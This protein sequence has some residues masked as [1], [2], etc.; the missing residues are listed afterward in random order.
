MLVNR[1]RRWL[2]TCA[3]LGACRGTEAS[4]RRLEAAY[5][6]PARAYHNIRHVEACLKDLDAVSHLV[7]NPTVLEAAIWFHDA[8]YDSRASDNEERSADLAA[9]TL[10]ATGVPKRPIGEIQRLIRHTKH[11]GTPRTLDG[12]IMVDI[13]LAILGASP[14]VFWRY[15]S[16]I[17]KEYAW[18]EASVYR[19]KRTEF[20]QKIL[21]RRRI[22]ATEF[23]F[24]KYEAKARRNMKESIGFNSHIVSL[25]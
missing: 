4:Y 17:R 2:K 25:R 13:D 8:I 11:S 1:H 12:R 15:E 18:V 6:S 23:F 10:T 3:A 7:A 5:R 9:A 24:E 14:A 20:L 16:A 22:Y 21:E 19:R